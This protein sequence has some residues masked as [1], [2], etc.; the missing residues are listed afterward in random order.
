MKNKITI[1]CIAILT[2]VFAIISCEKDDD[3]RDT[4]EQLQD[5]PFEFKTIAVGG[6][7]LSSYSPS[8]V[9][10]VNRFNSAALTKSSSA[11]HVTID[12]AYVKVLQSA[13][14]ESY[15]F[16]VNDSTLPSN[17]YK[18]YVIVEMRD[19]IVNQY[20]VDYHLDEF[21]HIDTSLSTITPVFG[22]DLLNQVAYKCGGTDMSVTWVD[23]YYTE[24]RCTAGGN[25]TVADGDECTAWGTTQMATRSYTA[26]YWS[27]EF[28]AAEPCSGGGGG[29]GS[30]G[31][32]GGSSGGGSNNNPPNDDNDPETIGIGIVP[33]LPSLTKNPCQH[34]DKLLANSV[35]KQNIQSLKTPA[36]LSLNYEKGFQI[37][38]TSIGGFNTNTIHGNPNQN[39]IQVAIDTTAGTVTGFIH[40]HYN[41]LVPN[42]SIG[43]IKTFSAIYQWRKYRQKPL[44]QLT[45]MV[46]SSGG[47][48]ALVI[49]DESKFSVEGRKLH[50][51][52][53]GGK[54]GIKKTYENIFTNQTNASKVERLMIDINNT[55]SKYGL[56]LMKAKNDLSGWN[57][58]KINQNNINSTSYEDCK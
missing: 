39:S 57:K 7:D 34:L 51:P 5:F 56:S 52:Q 16:R 21:N 8:I 50:E 2:C 31:G 47:V 27:V 58:V 26:G 28:I 4:T 33:N 13:E 41:G 54:N 55:L 11:N 14:F 44:D 42:F 17:V 20:M 22:D 18:N 43:D 29:G 30:S 37:S 38:S 15:I 36:T 12:T 53:F 10:K 23:G 49:D 40:T 9:E 48:Y 45:I 19:S 3:L 1:L 25:H 32:G 46:V 6:N 35:F 24:N